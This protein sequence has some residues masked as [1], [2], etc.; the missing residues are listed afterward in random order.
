MAVPKRLLKRAVD[1]N[2]VRRAARESWRL[3]RIDGG[4]TRDSALL[5]LTKLPPDFLQTSRPQRKRRWRTEIDTLMDQYFG[6]Q[7]HSARR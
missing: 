3:R 2:I 4:V 5:R 6:K 1:R 7:K